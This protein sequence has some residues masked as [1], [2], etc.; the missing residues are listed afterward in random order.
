MI[1]LQSAPLLLCSLG[2]EAIGARFA[3]LRAVR[4]HC[5]MLRGEEPESDGSSRVWPPQIML[6]SLCWL[7]PEW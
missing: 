2:C 4:V 1:G 3:G 7:P 5:L 6:L